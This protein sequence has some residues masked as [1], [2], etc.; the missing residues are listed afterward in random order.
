LAEFA[1]ASVARHDFQRNRLPIVKCTTAEFMQFNN[2]PPLALMEA[3]FVD[4]IPVG[5][6]PAT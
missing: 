5:V 6:K 4:A 1:S 2:Q 3:C